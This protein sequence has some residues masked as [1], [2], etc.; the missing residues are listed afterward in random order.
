L[1]TFDTN[2]VHSVD[3]GGIDDLLQEYANRKRSP[4]RPASGP[5]SQR[6]PEE[7]EKLRREALIIAAKRANS[8]TQPASTDS[9]AS[10]DSR[11]RQREEADDGLDFITPPKRPR[12]VRCWVL[13]LT[14]SCQNERA[15]TIYRDQVEIEMED[16]LSRLDA[17]ADETEPSEPDVECLITC[18]TR[19]LPV[20]TIFSIGSLMQSILN[21]KHSE[22]S[23]LVSNLAALSNLA[24]HIKNRSK[25]PTD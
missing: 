20:S 3:V 7:N 25:K 1:P 23:A 22:F 24:E 15:Q 10:T 18:L 13:V 21:D 8:T 16:E 5:A 2:L 4:P 11:K 6:D 19:P 14:D 17:E 9:A 12:L